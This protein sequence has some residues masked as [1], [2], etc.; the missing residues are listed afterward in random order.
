MPDIQEWICLWK[1]QGQKEQWPTGTFTQI[2]DGLPPLL[3]PPWGV[4]QKRLPNLKKKLY[5]RTLSTQQKQTHSLREQVYG[6]QGGRMGEGVAGEL[7]KDMR[8]LPFCN[9]Q[10][11]RTCHIAHGTLDG[12][13]VW[14]TTDTCIYVWL[15]PFAVHL[16]LSKHC[17]LISYTSMQNK[18]FKNWKQK[19]GCPV[20]RAQSVSAAAVR[21]ADAPSLGPLP[22]S[23]TNTAFSPHPMDRKLRCKRS[24]K[25]SQER[26]ARERL[27]LR[28]LQA[29]GPKG[30]ALLCPS[31]EAECTLK[32]EGSRRRHSLKADFS[33]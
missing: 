12:R 9:G 27:R 10:P 31:P 2:G 5:K 25:R 22:G 11:T 13:G 7:A 8:T 14:R 24:K 33:V 19:K 1:L 4:V 30:P 23:T 3:T 6:C 15:S 16:K 28:R 17:L 21:C 32:E 18:K 26:T 29:E 20:P